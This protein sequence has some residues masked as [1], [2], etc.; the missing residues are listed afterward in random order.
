M[1]LGFHRLEL[2]I[3]G[4]ELLFLLRDEFADLFVGD[5]GIRIIH[6]KSSLELIVYGHK[7]P[8]GSILQSEA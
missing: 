7:A 1:D 2:R 3:A 4:L 6:V 8:V 5:E